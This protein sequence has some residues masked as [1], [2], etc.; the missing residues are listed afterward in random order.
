MSAGMFSGSASGAIDLTAG[1]QKTITVVAQE[2]GKSAK[3]YTIP[4]TRLN[5]AG[6]TPTFSPAG[7]AVANG[8]KVTITSAG[9][10]AIYYT[11]NGTPPTTSSTNQATTPLVYTG[12]P[13]VTT[14]KALAVRAGYASS[15][16]G[17][18]AYWL[19][20]ATANLFSLVL[21]GPPANYAF[22]RATYTYTGVT[23]RNAVKSVKVTPTGAG[24]IRVD[25]ATV[26]SRSASASVY[27]FGSR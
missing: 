25:G 14:V 20:P 6:A 11:T 10:D 19:A 2:T 26:A 18:A 22:A 24:V 27:S 5:P 17:S 16:I 23:V 8:T 9:A 13:G 7:G 12:S 21:S 1:T 3:T 4:V 15:A